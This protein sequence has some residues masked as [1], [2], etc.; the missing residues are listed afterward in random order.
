MADSVQI[1]KLNDF[2]QQLALYMIA[3]PGKTNVEIAKKFGYS[4]TYISIIKNSDAFKA[5][6]AKLFNQQHAQ[7]QP[8]I[9]NVNAMTEL[10][11]EALNQKLST[12]GE[13]LSVGELRE[14]ADMGLRRLG[15]GALKNTPA[16]TVNVGVSVVVDR[17]DLEDARRKMAE[18]HGVGH[19]AKQLAAPETAPVQAPRTG[20]A[21]VAPHLIPDAEVVS[22]ESGS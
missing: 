18:V 8:I 17:G 3:H 11:L 13:Q 15:F 6:Y 9:D 22:P 2:H 21:S 19:S 12:I 14:V 7:L 20:V 1:L 4:P 10:A 16:P 5:F